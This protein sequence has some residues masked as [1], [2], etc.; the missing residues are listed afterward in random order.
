MINEASQDEDAA[1]DEV[2]EINTSMH[3]EEGTSGENEEEE[4]EE[5]E[6]EGEE[7]EGEEEEGEEEEGEEEEEDA[8]RPHQLVRS[9]ETPL[10]FLPTTSLADFVLY[11]PSLTY[12]NLRL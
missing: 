11:T 5:E 9:P 3:S 2:P 1:E 8:S 12:L 7:E 10:T 4:E 6:E